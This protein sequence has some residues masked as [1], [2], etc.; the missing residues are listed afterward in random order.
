MAFVTARAFLQALAVL[1]VTKTHTGNFTLGQTGTY[2]VTVSNAAGAAPTSGTVTVTDTVPASAETLVSM[3]GPGWTCPGTAANNC[4]RSDV[5]AR[6]RK[7]S[8]HY[9]NRERGSPGDVTAD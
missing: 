8:A 6:R 4:T 9:R 2:T 5:L 7:L 1:S 3:A